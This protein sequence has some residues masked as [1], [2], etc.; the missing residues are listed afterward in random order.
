LIKNISD[1]NQH[2]I[3]FAA[4]ARYFFIGIPSLR[5]E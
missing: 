2:L 5:Q 1:R 4:V 3:V